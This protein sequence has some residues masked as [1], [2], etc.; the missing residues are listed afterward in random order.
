MSGATKHQKKIT[1][2]FVPVIVT[3]GVWSLVIASIVLQDEEAAEK[4]GLHANVCV[5]CVE[6][7]LVCIIKLHHRAVFHRAAYLC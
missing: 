7:T 6:R 4:T 1:I 2:L 3:S 5:H